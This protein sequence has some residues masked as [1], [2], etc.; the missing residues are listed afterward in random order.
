MRSPAELPGSKAHSLPPGLSLPLVRLGVVRGG[1]GALWAGASTRGG[2][3]PHGGCEPPA[4]ASPRQARKAR[5]VPV[6][7]RV[8]ATP[9]RESNRQTGGWDSIATAAPGRVPPFRMSVQAIQRRRR[10]RG[11]APFRVP[12]ILLGLLLACCAGGALAIAAYVASVVHS[13]PG[14]AARHPVAPGSSSQVLAADGTRLGFIQSAELRT[15]VTWEQIPAQLK[16]ATVAIEDQ[17]F[18][19]DDAIDVT[20]I[21]RSAVR[22]LSAGE[23][24]QGASTITMQLIRNLYL[25]NYQHTFKQKIIEAKLAVEYAKHHSR[26]EILTSYL[27]SVPYGTLGGQTAIGVQAAAQMF[28]DKP[29]SQLTLTQSALLAG[30]PQA[31]SQ[32]NPFLYPAGR[33]RTAQRGAREDGPAALHNARP[34]RRR[35]GRAAGGRARQLL[36]PPHGRL[37]LRIRSPA[38]DRSLRAGDR[39][40][41]RPQG[42]HDAST[43]TS[44][45]WPVARSP[46]SSTSPAT[47]PRRSS[48]STR[49]NGYIETMAESKSYEESQFNLAAEGYRQPGSTFKAIDLAEALT[50]GVDP[51]TTYYVSHT[52]PKG[53]LASDPE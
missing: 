26:N 48:R 3:Q 31:P 11:T 2:R 52:L 47:P 30:L 1:A 29:A 53:W 36:H 16:E 18:Y 24:L 33:A 22:D 19:Q 7:L 5:E 9:V 20:G 12:L 28:F 46:K 39:R 34:G 21:L 27:N 15:P 4:G 43:C 23:A 25:P 6:T 8:P 42:L 49:A 13:A 44:S 14:L 32:S 35:G 40:T 45:T 41:R 51:D 37:L 17:R 38:A 50:R 10:H